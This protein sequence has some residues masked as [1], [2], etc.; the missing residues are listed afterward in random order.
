MLHPLGYISDDGLGPRLE[1]Q[2]PFDEGGHRVRGALGSLLI[3]FHGNLCGII[4]VILAAQAILQ[5]A[6]MLGED[7]KGFLHFDLFPIQNVMSYNQHWHP[8]VDG[9]RKTAE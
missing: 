4:A 2:L 7:S 1:D 9:K 5:M 3:S 6:G 8:L